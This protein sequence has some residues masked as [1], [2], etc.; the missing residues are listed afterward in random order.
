MKEII[1]ISEE[2]LISW[3]IFYCNAEQPKPDLKQYT[4]CDLD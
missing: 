2:F 3:D 4:S 1:N